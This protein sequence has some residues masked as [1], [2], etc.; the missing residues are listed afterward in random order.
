MT[1]LTQKKPCIW[2]RSK[3][4]L[5][6]HAKPLQNSS[7]E[8]CF[9]MKQT[10]LTLKRWKKR[11]EIFECKQLYLIGLSW[12]LSEV[13]FFQFMTHPSHVMT[14]LIG[15]K[16]WAMMDP[17]RAWEVRSPPPSPSSAH[18]LSPCTHLPASPVFVY[19]L[20]LVH[21]FR[22]SIHGAMRMQWLREIWRRI[23]RAASIEKVG[24]AH[25]VFAFFVCLYVC[26]ICQLFDV[27]KGYLVNRWTAR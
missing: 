4:L 6:M 19:S 26:C 17:L 14:V 25:R 8:W 22:Q 11:F 3:Y 23:N 12:G 13:F 20:S 1:L 7:C 24:C 18:R 27:I 5:H 2:G 16:I 10:M 9:I 15:T 21:I